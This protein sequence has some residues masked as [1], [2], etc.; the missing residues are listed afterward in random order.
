MPAETVR[1][2]LRAEGADPAAPAEEQLGLAWRLLRRAEARLGELERRRAEEMRDVRAGV[3][4]LV[5]SPAGPK[6]SCFPLFSHQ[7]WVHGCSQPKSASLIPSGAPGSPPWGARE[8][9]ASPQVKSSQHLPASIPSRL[10]DPS[11]KFLTSP[12]VTKAQRSR[13]LQ[14][15]EVILKTGGWGAICRPGVGKQ[16]QV[17]RC[18]LCFQVESYV[19]HVRNLTEERDALTT[20]YEK[21]NDQLRLELR[22]LQLQQGNP[23]PPQRGPRRGD[24]RQWRTGLSAKPV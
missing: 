21:E 6:R 17:E 14:M 19:G 2:W 22:R 13:V 24:G 4:P 16:A 18:F 12:D 11:V 7:Q 10:P 9:P 1:R 8:R 23:F 3:P 5:F 20:E 15:F